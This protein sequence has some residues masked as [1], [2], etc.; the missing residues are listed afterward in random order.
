MLVT[1]QHDELGWVDGAALR[2]S[3]NKE[4]WLVKTKLE[5]RWVS[6]RDLYP[7]GHRPDHPV[8]EA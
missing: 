2:P 1:F 5:E 7:F 3:P 8:A 4:E 6:P